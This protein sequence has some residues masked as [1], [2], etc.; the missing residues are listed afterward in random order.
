M[1]TCDILD[2]EMSHLATRG[3]LKR[4]LSKLRRPEAPVVQKVWPLKHD[5]PHRLA[6]LKSPAPM[7]RVVN[8]RDCIE[9]PWQR[10]I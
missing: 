9:Y 10:E 5:K 4:I 6:S 1:C 7:G 8:L 3:R 2:T